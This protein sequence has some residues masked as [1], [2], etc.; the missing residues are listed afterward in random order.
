M[1]ETY[2]KPIIQTEIVF[3]VNTGGISLCARCWGIS[4]GDGS[5]QK[6]HCKDY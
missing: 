4:Y 1:K 2:S 3:E 5:S 6:P